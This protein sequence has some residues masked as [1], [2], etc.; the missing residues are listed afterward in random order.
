MSVIL[1]PAAATDMEAIAL[2]YAHHVTDGTGSFETEP[3]EFAR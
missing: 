1:R 2:I 3:P